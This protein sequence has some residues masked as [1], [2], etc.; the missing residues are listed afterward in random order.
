MATKHRRR[1]IWR[2]PSDRELFDAVKRFHPTA[3]LR[4]ADIPSFDVLLSPSYD[5]LVAHVR[6]HAAGRAVRWIAGT[7]EF[8]H[9][10]AGTI[11][12]APESL[13]STEPR[14]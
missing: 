1:A 6:K 13:P 11:L 12:I 3:K 10:A 5:A 4:F 8:P 7:K 2:G 14:K 9:I